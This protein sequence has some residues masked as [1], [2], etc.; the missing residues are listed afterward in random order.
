VVQMTFLWISESH[1]GSSYICPFFKQNDNKN[2]EQY[3]VEC[4]VETYPA[5]RVETARDAQAEKSSC[6]LLS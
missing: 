6:T 4:T 2:T 3:N 1:L 5:L